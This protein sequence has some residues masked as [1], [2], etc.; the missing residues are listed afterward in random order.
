MQNTR[1]TIITIESGMIYSLLNKSNIR[2]Y[3][4]TLLAK[5]KQQM[6]CEL[7]QSV[8]QNRIFEQYRNLTFKQNGMNKK[9][10]FLSW[11]KDFLS[12]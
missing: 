5:Q 2:Q 4:I 11:Y 6:K 8:N 9:L 3:Q 12:S 7:Q 10:L 1:K